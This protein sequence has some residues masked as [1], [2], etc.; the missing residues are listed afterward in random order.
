M[1]K[2]NVNVESYVMEY[3]WKWRSILGWGL[4]NLASGM[5]FGQCI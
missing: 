3:K 4:E 2:S 1:T 5:G